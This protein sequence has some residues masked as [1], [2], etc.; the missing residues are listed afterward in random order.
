ML[1]D[2][3]ICVSYYMCDNIIIICVTILCCVTIRQGKT[4]CHT[5]GGAGQVYSRN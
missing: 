1:C 4:F 5:A 3:I 2:N